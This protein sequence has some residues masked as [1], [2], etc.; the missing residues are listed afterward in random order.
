M[1]LQGVNASPSK[2]FVV[3]EDNSLPCH[4]RYNAL[5]RIEYVLFFFFWFYYCGLL[6]PRE[7][8][9]GESFYAGDKGLSAGSVPPAL[10][11][12]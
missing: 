2:L 5:L 9:V 4:D 10:H 12:L 8:I 6:F 11:G 7:E 3:F 1:H